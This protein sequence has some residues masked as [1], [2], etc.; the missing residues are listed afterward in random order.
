MKH[1]KLYFVIVVMIIWGLGTI[2]YCRN[3]IP[4]IAFVDLNKVHDKFDLKIELEKEY[5]KTLDVRFQII[6]SL[7]FE[8]EILSNQLKSLNVKNKELENKYNLKYQ[9][10]L[11]KKQRLKEDNEAQVNKFDQQIN[12]QLSQYVQDYGNQHNYSYI[13]GANGSGTIMYVKENKDITD[14]VIEFINNRYNGDT[15]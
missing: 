1:F 4:Q 9:D 14:E 10:Y 15:D 6:D 11:I 13:I 8:L 2:L 12:I 7:E 3:Q 5:E